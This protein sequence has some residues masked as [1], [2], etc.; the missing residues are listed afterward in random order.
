M[1]IFLI[2]TKYQIFPEFIFKINL[3][4]I[5]N[6]MLPTKLEQTYCFHLFCE[7]SLTKHLPISLLWKEVAPATTT[8]LFRVLHILEGGHVCNEFPSSL[9][10][11]E[12]IL[13]MKIANPRAEE[14]TQWLMCFKY[15]R[16]DRNSD[17][18]EWLLSFYPQTE[19]WN[20][21]SKL[22][23]KTSWICELWVWLARLGESVNSEFDA[24][25][26]PQ[27]PG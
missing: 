10:S 1:V 5:G 11:S 9:F 18:H 4:F 2:N 20:L 7:A 8:R 21:Q 27:W 17:P 19:M 3:Y 23:S 22:T 13:P 12:H 25:T 15:M 26:L 6:K 14:M 24:E 16:E